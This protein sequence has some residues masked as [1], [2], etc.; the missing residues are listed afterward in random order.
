VHTKNK[1]EKPKLNQRSLFKNVSQEIY[2][3]ALYNYSRWR[4]FWAAY[5]GAMSA[6]QLIIMMNLN[7][8]MIC[9]QVE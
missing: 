9:L 2:L 6:A 4:T 3:N 1:Q 5:Q 8:G 7:I